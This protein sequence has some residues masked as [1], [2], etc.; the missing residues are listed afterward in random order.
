MKASKCLIFKVNEQ[1]FAIKTSCVLNII[2]KARMTELPESNN[3][4]GMAI[5][6]RGMTLP[7]IDMR[8][9]L[10]MVSSK[11]PINE[12]VL[13]VEVR[14]NDKLQIVGIS[15]DEVVEVTELDDFMAY[16][17]MPLVSGSVYDFREAVIVRDNEPVII[18]NGGKLHYKHI[19]QNHY[20]TKAMVSVN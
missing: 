20:S 17:Y 15:I 3:Q 4:N 16:P 12:C 9:I 8:D 19:L 13:V 10:G 6:F 11:Q 2:E 7:L 18:I 5:V 1:K 14:L